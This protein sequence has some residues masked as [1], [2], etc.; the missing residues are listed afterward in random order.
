MWTIV[1]DV[2]VD[3][4]FSPSVLK[5][6]CFDYH[7]FS[8]IIEKHSFNI[9]VFLNKICQQHKEVKLHAKKYYA[10]TFQISRRKRL[11]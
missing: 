4:D 9:Q 6:Q 3:T 1:Y 7:N 5:W 8:S 10:I 2:L 11:E